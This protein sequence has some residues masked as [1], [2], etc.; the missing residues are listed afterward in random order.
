M[1]DNRSMTT[2]PTLFVL[3]STIDGRYLPGTFTWLEA[4]AELRTQTFVIVRRLD[5]VLAETGRD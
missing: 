1:T 5:E 2:T 3:Q 4:Q